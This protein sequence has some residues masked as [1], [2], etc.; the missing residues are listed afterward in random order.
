[1]VAFTSK[2]Q[3]RHPPLRYRRRRRGPSSPPPPPELGSAPASPRPRSRDL[4]G[5]TSEI[6]PQQQ[7]SNQPETVTEMNGIEGAEQEVRPRVLGYG[8]LLAALPMA[9]IQRMRCDHLSPTTPRPPSPILPLPPPPPSAKCPLDSSWACVTDQLES[10]SCV[11]GTS[12]RWVG[13]EVDL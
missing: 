8:C 12:A 6:K 4:H 9:Q 10:S 11:C 7:T 1:M 3:L 5:D 13:F 2:Q